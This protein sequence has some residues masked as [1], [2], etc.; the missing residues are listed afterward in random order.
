MYS[1]SYIFS[2][3]FS[4]EDEQK[5][6]SPPLFQDN[7]E[8]IF[9]RG[10]CNWREEVYIFTYSAITYMEGPCQPVGVLGRKTWARK[11]YSLWQNMS[12]Y[13]WPEHPDSWFE[14]PSAIDTIL[15]FLNK[16]I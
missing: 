3:C 14:K 4:T 10:Q 11:T 5:I 1:L 6:L 12:L 8:I 9:I 7:S 2:F 16:D 13:L 15:C